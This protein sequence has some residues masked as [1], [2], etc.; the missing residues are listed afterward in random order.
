MPACCCIKKVQPGPLH[1]RQAA[2]VE[3]GAQ[4]L[5]LLKRPRG[6]DGNRKLASFLFLNYPFHETP[7]ENRKKQAQI[8]LKKLFS[9]FLLFIL[10]T[11]N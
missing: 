11:E 3:V 7:W 8:Q 4:N 2:A 9:N 6:T 10:S 5:P 1:V